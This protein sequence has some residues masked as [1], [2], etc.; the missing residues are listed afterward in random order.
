MAGVK[1]KNI[2]LFYNYLSSFVKKD[3]E[4]LSEEFSV[5]GFDFYTPKK[6]GTPFSFLKQFWFLLR[7]AWTADLIVCQFAGYHSVLPVLFGRLL[8]KPSL[9]IVGGTDAHY[10]PQIGY[11][12]WQ[13]KGLEFF[14]RLTFVACTH[15]APK[16]KTLMEYDYSYDVQEPS[17]QGIYARIPGLKTPFT[18]IPNGYDPAKWI[19]SG[20][21][22]PN[23][24][25][26][27]SGAW[28]Y[29]FQ[30]QLK[31]IDLILA[32][33]PRF[34][35]CRF[36][37]L[38]VDSANRLPKLP[39]NV[40]VLPAT[41]NNQ[42]PAV[43]GSCTYYLQLSMAEGFPNA[44]CESMLCGCVPV[45]SAVF[46]MPEIVGDSGF[47]LPTRSAETLEGVLR[48]ALA[49]D[50][51]ARS[52]AARERIASHYTQAMRREKLLALCSRLM[53]GN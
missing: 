5:S 17:A 32:V 7:H 1:R 53:N 14:T 11:G 52:K 38:G 31:G 51:S 33:A 45:V 16:H 10:F 26:T 35:E 21:R 9:V 8:G 3:V 2:L 13:K 19:A 36:I 41:P 47:V 50:R 43:F 40:E 39:A 42:L 29:P 25:I 46:S 28:E 27:V 23:T 37:I 4:M 22:Q 34:P 15:I 20:E 24:F 49:G 30:I 44:L 6:S 12:N 48:E 18:E